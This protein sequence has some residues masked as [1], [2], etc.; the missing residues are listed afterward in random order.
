MSNGKLGLACAAEHTSDIIISVLYGPV[1]RLGT[2]PPFY[3]TDWPG[4]AFML[5]DAKIIR[6]G[7]YL[8][9]VILLLTIP[10]VCSILQISFARMGLRWQPFADFA[11]E[12][13]I[14]EVT[15]PELSLES[16]WTGTFQQQ[17][18]P[19]FAQELAWRNA[20]TRTLN[21]IEYSTFG[22]TL[23]RKFINGKECNHLSKGVWF[24]FAG[25]TG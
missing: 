10:L 14:G 7:V 24:R 25:R 3:D 2:W 16:I 12:G 19:Y 15:E 11:L 22:Q 23:N 20:L 21:Q 6:R 1:F 17:F 13:V 5:T 8:L 4:D 9:A 18:E